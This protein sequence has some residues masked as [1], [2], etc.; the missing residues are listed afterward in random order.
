M[1]ANDTTSA[2]V[3]LAPWQLN[4]S[5]ATVGMTVRSVLRSLVKMWRAAC[6]LDIG[7]LGESRLVPDAFN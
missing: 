1:G 7:Q 4:W 3:M 2:T 5:P 6:T